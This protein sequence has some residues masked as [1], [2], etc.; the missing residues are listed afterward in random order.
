VAS[1]W[2][3]AAPNGAPGRPVPFPGVRAR[4]D[5]TS[6]Q[7]GIELCS[8][9]DWEDR[10]DRYLLQDA[11]TASIAQVLAAAGVDPFRKG[12]GFAVVGLVTGLVKLSEREYRHIHFLPSVAAALRAQLANA[13]E[14]YLSLYAPYARYGVITTG[15]RCQVSEV[16]HRV[17][18][19]DRK[20]SRWHHEICMP[21]GIDVHFRGVE[22]PCDEAVTFHVHANVIFNPTRHLRPREWRRFLRQ[23]RAFFGAHWK[24]NG[25]LE[26][27]REAVKYV[28]KRD[29]VLRLAAL[30]PA[31]LVEL[32]HQLRGLHL[33]QPLGG[34]RDWRH[35]LADL[36]QKIVP[37]HE[38]DGRK[39][40][41]VQFPPPRPRDDTQANAGDRLPASNRILCI[42]LPRALFSPWKEPVAL[43]EN[44]D[45]RNLGHD[46]MLMEHVRKAVHDWTAKGLLPPPRCPLRAGGSF[47]VHTST[48]G[49][50]AASPEGAVLPVEI[51]AAYGHP[52]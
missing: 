47:T 31:V 52:P 43:V 13:L 15:Q 19:L 12:S 1:P 23:T 27:V 3:I 32:Y 40:V 9:A 29:D 2:N 10:L 28:M 38:H 48:T 16:K 33:V 45:I 35:A 17:V 5:V 37:I 49:V 41:A 8:L 22:L 42:C 11:L 44:L 6:G 20:V 24:D 18:Q 50:R 36:N 21:L 51:A 14:L 46:P 39:L 26:G 4:A 34:F 7:A 30:H 25:K